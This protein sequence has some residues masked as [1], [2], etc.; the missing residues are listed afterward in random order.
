FKVVRENLGR[1][2]VLKVAQSN[3]SQY[4]SRYDRLKAGETPNVFNLEFSGGALSDLNIYNLHFMIGLFGGPEEISYVPNTHGKGV[5][6]AGVSVLA[7]HGSFATCVCS[8]YTSSEHSGLLHG[9]DAYIHAGGAANTIDRVKL[10]ADADTEIT[11]LGQNPN[12]MVAELEAFV[13]I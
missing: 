6:A 8:T 9:D 1:I 5:D 11:D 10:H 2:G 7:Y 3:Y 4:S 13:E 12:N